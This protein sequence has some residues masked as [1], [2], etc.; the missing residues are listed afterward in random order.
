MLI[1]DER[2]KQISEVFKG[3]AEYKEL[4]RGHNS[5]ATSMMKGLV[6]SLSADKKERKTISKVL[7]KAYKEW[8]EA[9]K[10]EEDTLTE[11]IDLLEKLEEK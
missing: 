11:A 10:G 4:A 5:T 7:K 8:V 3:V 1:D 6:E 9:Q 2:K